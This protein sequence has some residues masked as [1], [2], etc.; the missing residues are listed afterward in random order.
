M[1]VAA[2]PHA[3][4]PKPGA[5]IYIVEGEIAAGKTE[6]VKAIAAELG[7]R[8]LKVTLVLEPVDRW[9]EIGILQKFYGA[10][11]RHGYGFQ[12]YVF[13]TRILEIAAA[14]TAAPDAD[15]YLLER[16]PATDTIFMYAQRELVDPVEMRMYT[17]WCAAFNLMLPIDLSKAK[18]LY[19][20]TDLSQCMSRLSSRAREGELPSGESAPEAKT[21]AVGGVSVGY[22]Q[23]LRRLHEAFFLGRGGEEFPGLPKSPFP[24]ASVVCIGPELAN[25]DWRKGA[26]NEKD[27]EQ[28][29]ALMGL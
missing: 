1:D 9:R 2:S 29:V 25:L 7:R 14:V 16:S 3:A 27:I 11:D 10:P 18:V 19:L 20:R 15:V 23:H 6:L 21:T 24:S 22:Q 13:A 12:T 5:R 26:A 28:I 4:R 8:G 17:T